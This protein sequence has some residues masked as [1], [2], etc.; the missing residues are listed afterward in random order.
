MSDKYFNLLDE[1]EDKINIIPIEMIHWQQAECFRLDLDPNAQ[2]ELVKAS[3]Y[4]WRICRESDVKCDWR[5]VYAQVCDD[6]AP[7]LHR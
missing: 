2:L 6:N 3:W 7:R 1:P 4:L 5:T